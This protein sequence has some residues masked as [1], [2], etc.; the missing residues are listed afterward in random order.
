G[1]ALFKSFDRAGKNGKVPMPD[2]NSE[3]GRQSHGAHAMLCVG[4]SDKSQAFIVRNSWGESWGHKGYCYIP[5]AYMT[6]PEYCW[7]CWKIASVSDLD[8]TAGVWY[9][10]DENYY[11][12]DEEEDE[13]SDYEYYYEEDDVENSDEEDTV[14]AY[15]DESEEED[16]EDYDD[17]SEEEDSEDYDDE[18]DEE[19]SEDYDDESDEEEE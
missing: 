13:D 3:E 7:D 11:E 14:G 19:D 9:E 16:S 4:Y 6:N 17:E 18:S 10:D 12:E 2:P 8:F 5:Y 15:D 1:L